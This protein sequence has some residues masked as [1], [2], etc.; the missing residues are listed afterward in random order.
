MNSFDDIEEEIPYSNL[1]LSQ[2]LTELRVKTTTK[3]TDG[4]I[5]T[6]IERLKIIQQLDS[7]DQQQTKN[8]CISRPFKKSITNTI[9]LSVEDVKLASYVDK[10]DCWNV[11]NSLFRRVFVYGKIVLIN[12]Y[13]KSDKT[14]LKFSLDDSSDIVIATMN[15]SKESRRL[16]KYA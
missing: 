3:T 5:E 15:I 12:Q 16:G 7:A 2:G 4:F 9:C 11:F 10:N 8:I 14:C 13:S 1:Q 6:R